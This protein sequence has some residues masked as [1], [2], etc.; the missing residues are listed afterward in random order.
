MLTLFE[1]N[2]AIFAEFH[3]R[4]YYHSKILKTVNRFN[5]FIVNDSGLRLN[6]FF[7]KNNWRIFC[8]FVCFLTRL[9]KDKT[10]QANQQN[11]TQQIRGHPDRQEASLP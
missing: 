4:I 9:D 5:G 11:Q 8:L 7:P 1:S 10:N 3:F 2:V 6:A